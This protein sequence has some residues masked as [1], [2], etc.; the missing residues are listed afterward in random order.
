M[1]TQAEIQFLG[2]TPTPAIRDAIDGH[3]AELDRLYSRITACRVAVK[4]PSPHH[5]KS[6]LYVHVRL[7]LPDGREVNVERTP[8]A[9]ER[10]ADL[11]FA[12]DDA[13]KHARR[14]LED[15]VRALRAR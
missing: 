14:Q 15:Q 6:G 2:L 9:D 5:Q 8:T 1:Q 7:E 10:Y 12:I 11:A 4:A 13:F 3:V